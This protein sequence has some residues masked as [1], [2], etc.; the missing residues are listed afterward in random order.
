MTDINR[1]VVLRA[2]PDP[3][4][5]ADLFETVEV[6][7]PG[8][9]PRRDVDPSDLAQYRSCHARLDCVSG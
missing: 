4:V 6:P 3:E 9:W 7:M 5:T 1:Y 8:S 2:R